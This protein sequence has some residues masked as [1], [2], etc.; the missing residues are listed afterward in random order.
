MLSTHL[1]VISIEVN[2]EQG[3]QVIST[4]TSEVMEVLAQ[5]L[6]L[7]SQYNRVSVGL[8]RNAYNIQQLKLYAH[9]RRFCKCRSTM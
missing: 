9:Y 2:L 7:D 6:A 8:N 5:Y 4:A 3:R 1:G